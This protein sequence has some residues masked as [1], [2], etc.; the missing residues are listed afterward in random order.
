[1]RRRPGAAAG[2]GRRGGLCRLR[3]GAARLRQQ[4]RLQGGRARALRRHRFRSG[5]GACGRC[6]GR[7]A[8]ALRDAALP[9][10]RAGVARR[11]GGRGKG[12]RRALRRGPDR[13]RGAGSRA[14]AGAGVRGTAARCH[15]GEPAGA[16]ARHHPDGD[17]QQVRP[18]GGD[19]RQQVGDVGRLCDALRRHERRLQP[20]QGSLQD[21]GLPAGAAAQRLEAGW[22][23]RARRAGDPGEHPHPRADRRAPRKPDRPGFI[24]AL[25][26]PRPDPR[27]PRRARAAGREHRRRGLRARDRDEGGAH[28]RSRGVQALS[29]IHI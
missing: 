1:M 16:R 10:H 12:A 3:A 2:G 21:R 22:C 9:L 20:R 15:R 28:A 5:G 17:L 11:R 8:R 25:R 18:D 23:A 26:H 7:R 27:A 6:A 19:D 24:A 4:E 13:E 29:L 14:G